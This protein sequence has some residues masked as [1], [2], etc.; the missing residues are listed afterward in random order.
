MTTLDLCRRRQRFTRQTVLQIV[1]H[2]L[3]VLCTPEY[4]SYIVKDQKIAG[5]CDVFLKN[6]RP[7]MFFERVNFGSRYLRFGMHAGTDYGSVMAING[8]RTKLTKSP[9]TSL[10]CSINNARRPTALAI[11]ANWH[12]STLYNSPTSR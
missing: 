8:S 1:F 7:S 9:T 4:R 11:I 5:S 2:R 10:R 12:M 3:Q 6:P